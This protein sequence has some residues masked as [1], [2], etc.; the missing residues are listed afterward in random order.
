[1]LEKQIRS[2]CSSNQ[3]CCIQ[4][5]D[6]S[7]GNR[8]GQSQDVLFTQYVT[9]QVH[10]VQ[11]TAKYCMYCEFLKVGMCVRGVC[12][13]HVPFALDWDFTTKGKL[14]GR[15]LNCDC[16]RCRLIIHKVSPNSFFLPM[17]CWNGF[18]TALF[19]VISDLR[20]LD[21]T[22]KRCR[23]HSTANLMCKNISQ[24]ALLLF[25]FHS[26]IIPLILAPSHN[27]WIKLHTWLYLQCHLDEIKN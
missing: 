20:A 26:L 15:I 4:F 8:G 22:R 11:H 5:S 7:S 23:F 12:T 10:E 21:M 25:H 2:P 6:G 17:I 16:V 1:M 3:G 9:C 14:N 24:E 13:H 19:D 27:N 18:P